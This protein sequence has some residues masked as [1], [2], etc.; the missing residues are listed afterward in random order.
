M[1][2]KNGRVK[3]GRVIGQRIGPALQALRRR[4]GLTLQE[5]AVRCSIAP[6]RLG[7][8]ECGESDVSLQELMRLS[9]ALGVEVSYFTAYH[10]AASQTEQDLRQMLASV[11]V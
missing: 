11:D 6:A 10:T 3:S 5:L 8:I 7:R 9:G 2:R 4:D 1:E